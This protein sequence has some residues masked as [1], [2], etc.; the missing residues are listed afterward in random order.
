M[1]SMMRRLSKLRLGFG[2]EQYTTVHDI[3]DGAISPYRELLPLASVH[4]ASIQLLV[5]LDEHRF[6][7]A[8]D[9]GIVCIW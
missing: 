8:S 1:A 6:A 3:T 4:S 9:D 7:S 2:G 5:P